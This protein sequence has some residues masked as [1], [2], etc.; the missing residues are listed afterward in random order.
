MTLYC[1][2]S[3]LL[4]IYINEA[5]TDDVKRLVGSAD[6]L[7]TSAI[8]LVEIR[9][10][11]GRAVR[12]RRLDRRSYEAARNRFDEDWTTV[13]T[14]RPDSALLRLAADLSERLSLRALDGIHLASFQQLLERTDDEIEF[15][16]F[17]ERLVKAARKLG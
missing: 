1:D 3:S 12:E 17:D 7:V 2:S 8:T 10:A 11:L 15:S 6:T 9:A 13:V 4:K 14:V 16:S 5:H